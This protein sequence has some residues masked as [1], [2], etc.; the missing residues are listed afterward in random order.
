MPLS[1]FGEMKSVAHTLCQ[2]LGYDLRGEKTTGEKRK[3][4][5]DAYIHCGAPRGDLK[6]P[7]VSDG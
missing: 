5:V 3:M 1:K 6:T 2:E 7:G 4:A